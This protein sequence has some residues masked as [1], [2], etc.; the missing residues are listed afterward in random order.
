MENKGKLILTNPK[1]LAVWEKLFIKKNEDL[2]MNFDIPSENDLLRKY[3]GP[4]LE[5]SQ[6]E[7]VE[8][9]KNGF[10]KTFLN[11]SELC[12]V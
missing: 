2:V 3:C 12:G 1:N 8:T 5:V 10:Q 9:G 11:L 7:T 6:S 4:S